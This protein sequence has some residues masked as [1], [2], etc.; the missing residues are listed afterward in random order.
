MTRIFGYFKGQDVVLE[1]LDQEIKCWTLD[2]K[3]LV[4]INDIHRQN[5]RIVV[6]TKNLKLGFAQYDFESIVKFYISNPLAVVC[7]VDYVGIGTMHSVCSA[8]EYIDSEETIP[9][10]PKSPPL[11]PKKRLLCQ[12]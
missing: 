7:M 4:S 6:S 12:V 3:T 2:K 11:G 1:T 5:L 9:F 10:V 8:V